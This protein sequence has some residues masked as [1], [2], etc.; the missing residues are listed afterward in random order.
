M[1]TKNCMIWF[2]LSITNNLLK[3][4][5]LEMKLILLYLMTLMSA[6]S[7]W[8]GKWMTIIKR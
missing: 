6:M 7:G 8:W 2:A 5:I 1:T 3:D 4:T